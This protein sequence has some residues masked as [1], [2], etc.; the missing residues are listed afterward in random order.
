MQIRVKSGSPRSRTPL[1]YHL[2]GPCYLDEINQMSS[3]FD[4]ASTFPHLETSDARFTSG[5]SLDDL[6]LWSPPRLLNGASINHRQTH[7]HH[8]QI[9][10]EDG[11]RW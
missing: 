10:D 8:T 11:P 3:V 5:I 7:A 1:E 2:G 6:P 9:T 4:F